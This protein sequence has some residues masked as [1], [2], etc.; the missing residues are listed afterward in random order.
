MIIRQNKQRAPD[1]NSEKYVIDSWR[2]INR[3]NL[4]N[5]IRYNHYAQMLLILLIMGG[6]LR[7]YN[8][9]YNSLWL[10]EACTYDFAQLSLSGIL[11]LTTKT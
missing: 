11:E 10:D 6:I 3:K 8:L 9:G 4:K 2:D 7:F 5:V 1:S